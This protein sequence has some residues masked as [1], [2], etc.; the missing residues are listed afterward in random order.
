VKEGGAA[1]HGGL[2]L[3]GVTA[4]SK[5]VFER[6]ECGEM[7]VDQ[8]IVGELPEVF[9]GLELGGIDPLCQGK[10][11]AHQRQRHAGI[12]TPHTAIRR[13]SE[14]APAEQRGRGLGRSARA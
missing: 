4:S 11:A 12:Q 1:E 14:H 8:R 3:K 2:A 10:L 7:L 6:G 9:G 5:G 13:Q